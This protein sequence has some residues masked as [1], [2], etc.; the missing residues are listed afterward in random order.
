M[1]IKLHQIT[2]KQ[3]KKSY[4]YLYIIIQRKVMQS[5]KPT[6][7]QID[8]QPNPI[9]LPIHKR[10]NGKGYAILPTELI[11]YFHFTKNQKVEITFIFL[12]KYDTVVL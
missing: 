2:Y 10:S 8:L 11:K 3:K 1:K 9:I 12:L 4:T 5:I 7:V 6:S